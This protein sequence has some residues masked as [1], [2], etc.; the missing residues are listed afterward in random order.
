MLNGLFP[1]RTPVNNS[2][3]PRLPKKNRPKWDPNVKPTLIMKRNVLKKLSLIPLK[4]L[5]F[6]TNI[7]LVVISYVKIFCIFF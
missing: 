7:A 1:F 6:V 3:D 4:Y 5:K 2:S